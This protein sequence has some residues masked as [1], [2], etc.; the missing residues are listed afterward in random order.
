MNPKYRLVSA[1]D[2]ARYVLGIRDHISV[3]ASQIP[4]E[5]VNV[6]KRD[7]VNSM[8]EPTRRSSINKL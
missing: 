3:R 1:S 4:V 6:S 5:A 8:Q 7:R 2:L